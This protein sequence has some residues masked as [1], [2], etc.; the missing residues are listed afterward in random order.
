[1]G[2][3]DKI[4][5]QAGQVSIKAKEGTAQM[6][7]KFDTMQATRG[8]ETM[9]RDLGAAY[10]AEQRQGGPHDAV[11]E[12][13]A[14]LDARAAQKGPIDVSTTGPQAMPSQAAPTAG[15]ESSGDYSLDD[16]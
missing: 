8:T 1:M 5:A 13:L 7:A 15:A 11:E 10:Y 2:L 14:A 3:M 9:L 6:Q 4:K 16:L 12:A